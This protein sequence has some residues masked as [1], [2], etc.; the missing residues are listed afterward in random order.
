VGCRTLAR[1]P[2]INNSTE[3]K[4]RKNLAASAGR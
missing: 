2:I 4:S 1:F 3:E